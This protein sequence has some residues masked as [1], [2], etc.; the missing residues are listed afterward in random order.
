MF[1]RLFAETPRTTDNT[2]L[3]E[4]CLKVPPFGLDTPVTPLSLEQLE[5]VIEMPG[6]G[7]TSASAN[8]Q[9]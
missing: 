3:P 7:G 4:V 2:N 8:L 9:I 6:L 5:V 1:K